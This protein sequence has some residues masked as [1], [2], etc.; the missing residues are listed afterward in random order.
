MSVAIAQAVIKYRVK[1][2]TYTTYV[3]SPSGDLVQYYTGTKSNITK[4]YVDFANSPRSLFLVSISAAYL[5]ILEV[6]HSVLLM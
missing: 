1:S 2:G 6:L 5:K 3:N 4:I